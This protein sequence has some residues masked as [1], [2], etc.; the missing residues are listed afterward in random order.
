M[1]LHTTQGRYQCCNNFSWLLYNDLREHTMSKSG[2]AAYYDLLPASIG[3]C[4]RPR[5]Y[6]G[7]QRSL[8]TSSRSHLCEPGSA[9]ASR[10]M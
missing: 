5:T 3:G 2:I 6:L 10:Q 7:D 1:A 8:L 9:G 4:Q